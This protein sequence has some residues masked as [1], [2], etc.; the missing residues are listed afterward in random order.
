MNYLSKRS[1]EEKNMQDKN[2]GVSFPKIS[3]FLLQGIRTTFQ[4]FSVNTGLK[5]IKLKGEKL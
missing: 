1:Q 5:Q 2:S 3:L 4:R